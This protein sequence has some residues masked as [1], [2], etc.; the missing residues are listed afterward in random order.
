[1]CMVQEI[2]LLE[3]AADNGGNLYRGNR[4]LCWRSPPP[5]YLLG[6]EA[7]IEYEEQQKIQRVSLKRVE[8]KPE[9][10]VS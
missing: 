7:W 8:D 3:T 5:H 4:L 6:L 2:E 1:M 10:I 9:S